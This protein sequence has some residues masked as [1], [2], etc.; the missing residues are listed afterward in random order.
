[1]PD[2]IYHAKTGTKHDIPED[3]LIDDLDMNIVEFV[4]S[5]PNDRYRELFRDF[6]LSGDAR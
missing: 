6:I 1:L 2:R 4:K 3:I 5:H